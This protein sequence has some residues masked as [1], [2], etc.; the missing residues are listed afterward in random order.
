[1]PPRF[2][3]DLGREAASSL[4]S[5]EHAAE[6]ADRERE[7][8][9]ELPECELVPVVEPA[10]SEPESEPKSSSSRREGGIKAAEVHDD[11]ARGLVLWPR[12]KRAGCQCMLMVLRHGGGNGRTLLLTLLYHEHESESKAWIHAR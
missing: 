11:L 6:H 1:V 8:E 10:A 12:C 2:D 5:T 7:G 9:R 4:L 3:A